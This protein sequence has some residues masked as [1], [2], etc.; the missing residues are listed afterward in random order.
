MNRAL[1]LARI[2]FITLCVMYL[3][4]CSGNFATWRTN[5]MINDKYENISEYKKNINELRLNDIA[6]D[7]VFND[8]KEYGRDIPFYYVVEGLTILIGAQLIIGMI[9]LFVK[10]KLHLIAQI[11]GIEVLIL[12]CNGIAQILTTVPDAYG[13]QDACINSE[14]SKRGLWILTRISSEY[15]GDMIWSGHTFHIILASWY[16]YRIYPK[17]YVIHIFN[18]IAV[19]FLMVSMVILRAH[20][21]IDIWLS[22]LITFLVIGNDKI[23]RTVSMWMYPK[24]IDDIE[25]PFDIKEELSMDDRYIENPKTFYGYGT[26]GDPP[27]Y[28]V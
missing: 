5:K 24:Y 10:N 19:L 20:Y 9:N 27:I 14:Y 17:Y 1:F 13:L 12:F 3:F 11:F 21:S 15:C 6:N 28:V 7:Y 23:V 8:I 26:E 2:I 22:I 16:V 4:S 18:T 25:E